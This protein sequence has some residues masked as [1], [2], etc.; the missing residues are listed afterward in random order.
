MIENDGLL[1][2]LDPIGDRI[3]NRAFEFTGWVAAKSPINAVWLPAARSDRLATNDRP[4]VERVFPDRFVL[5]FA[6]KCPAKAIGPDGLRIAVQLNGKTVELAHPVP[7]PLTAAPHVERFLAAL[8]LA[9]LRLRERIGSKPSARFACVLRRHLIARRL[10]GGVFERRHTDALLAD[11]AVALP[12]AFF[13]QVGANDGFTGD[14]LYPL[15]SRGD[16]RWRGVLVEPVAH[17]FA[18]LSQRH[19]QNPALQLEQ[20]AIGERDGSM[21]IHRLTR[22]P[23]DSLWLDQIPSLEPALVEQNAAQ[24]GKTAAQLVEEEVRCLTV[25]TLLQRH[26]IA[27]LDLL[28]IDAEGWDWRILRQF[29]FK[30]LRPKL[31]LYEH[32]HLPAEEREA[33]HEFLARFGYDWVETKEG[34]TLAWGRILA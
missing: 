32:Q 19:A 27:H 14:P 18:E 9:W 23:G 10:R 11:F 15:I 13:L 29:D 26:G 24:F 31:I 12:D 17:L 28:V 4:D 20:A 25:A 6:G 3:A 21:V 5:G 34:D 30:A 1:V 8:Q 2:H 22:T 16:T 33:A 7:E